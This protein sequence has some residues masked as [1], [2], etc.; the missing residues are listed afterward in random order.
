[1]SATPALPTRRRPATIK[2]VARLS[3]VSTA[4]VTRV[5]QGQPSV[6]EQTRRRVEDAVRMLGYRPHGLA[7]ALVTRTSNTVGMLLPESGDSFWGGIASGIEERALEAGYSVLFATGHDRLNRESAM[8][9]LFLGKRVDGIVV[10][11]GVGG[12]SEWF[13]EAASH[14]PLVIV[15]SHGRFTREDIAMA[16]DAPPHEALRMVMARGAGGPGV[17]HVGFDS[18]GGAR[19]LVQDLVGLGHRR[20]AFVGGEPIRPTLLR[21]LGF[22]IAL[23]EA[24]LRPAAIRPTEE[25][26]EGG[27]EAALE[28]LRSPEPP[29]A[30]VAYSDLLAIGVLRA[31]H[32]LKIR[33]PEDVS[34]VGF[35]DIEIAAFVEPPLT[36][37][38]QPTAEMGRLAM[39]MM[40]EAIGSMRSVDVPGRLIARASSGP[41]GSGG[42]HPRPGPVPRV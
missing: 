22:R 42:G 5:L 36:T 32:E 11:G 33:V 4:T 34:V 20:L 17:G 37:V 28:L 7:R 23:E 25:T 13:G 24:G 16:Q 40:L 8:I 1:V 14:I 35:D 18:I 15:D 12:P 41:A 29:T 38:A 39:D 31:A 3:G 26:L 30:I 21:I 9:E 27:R 10:A 19:L 6:K 2:D